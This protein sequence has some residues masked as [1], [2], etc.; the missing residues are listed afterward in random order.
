MKGAA[1][2]EKLTGFTGKGTRFMLSQSFAHIIV[3]LF[4]IIGNAAYFVTRGR[5]RKKIG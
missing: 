4:V 5:E 1:E 3:V 2:F